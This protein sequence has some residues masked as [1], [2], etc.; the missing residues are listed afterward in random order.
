MIP[1]AS[2]ETHKG[3]LSD[4][5]RAI[6]L[7]GNRRPR[8]VQAWRHGH[9]HQRPQ[10]KVAEALTVCFQLHDRA[11]AHAFLKPIRYA[12]ATANPSERHAAL[13]YLNAAQHPAIWVGPRKR[14]A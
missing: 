14:A 6:A 7:R 9:E 12:I 13:Q 3:H 10:Q 5:D 1:S 8:T 4:L 2:A 11:A